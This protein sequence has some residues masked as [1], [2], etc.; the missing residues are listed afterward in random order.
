MKKGFTLVEVLIVVSIIAVLASAVFFS[1]LFSQIGKSRDSRRI[2]ELKTMQKLL[3]D[4]Y[5]DNNAYLTVDT[6]SIDGLGCKTN[7]SRFKPY[8]SSL[9]CDPQ[10]PNHTYA[11]VSDDGSYQ[12]YRIYALLEYPESPEAKSNPCKNGCYVSGRNYNFVVT[13]PNIDIITYPD[14]PVGYIGPLTGNEPSPLPT[15]PPTIAPSSIPTVGPTSTPVPTTIPPSATPF[16][17][18]SQCPPDP[19]TKYCLQGSSC[20]NCG[21]FT[22]CNLA[23]G[24]NQI[25]G[26]SLCT[27]PCHE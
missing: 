26:N 9:P 20:N 15:T 27:N 23:C 13:S 24:G 11:Y 1:N 10:Y 25:F 14:P 4:Y 8:I 19:G 21:T 5:N 17:T 22:N 12:K 16:I 3:E 2:Q 7:P 6:A 18:L